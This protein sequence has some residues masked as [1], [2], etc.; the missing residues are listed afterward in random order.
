[1]PAKFDL[2]VI[3][4]G[5]AATSVAYPCRTAGWTVAIIDDRPFGGTC[6]NRGCDPKK[7]LVGVAELADS[8]RR[9]K[10]HGFTAEREHVNW[11]DLMRFKRTF[12]DPVP[13]NREREFAEAGIQ[14]YKGVARFIDADT[15]QIGDE[16]LNGEHFAIASGSGPGKLNIPGEDLLI[17][18]DQ[19]LDLEQL[20]P[21]IVFIGGG[22]IGFE[23]AHIAARAGAH[24]TIL[25]RSKRPLH[26]FDADIVDRLVDHTR[27]IGIDVRLDT[28]VDR[29]ERRGDRIVVHANG[30][31]E[32]FEASLAVHAAGRV[33]LIHNLN[34]AAA[35]I[36]SSPHGITVNEFLQSVSNPR[37][38]AA[39]DAA[40]SGA[41]QLTPIATYDGGI[42]AHNLLK[43]NHQRPIYAGCASTVFTIP[44]LASV[45]LTE[46]TARK[47]NLD[48]DVQ[49]Q[50]T[51]GWYSSRRIAEECSGFK[52]IIE[53]GTRRIL[54]AHILGEGSEEVINLFALAIRTNLTA[55]Q[56]RDNL[57]AYPTHSSNMSYMV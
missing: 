40:A 20:P 8:A 7:V 53:R 42:V 16:K 46:D 5:V 1:M 48:F 52:L 47:Q 6:A 15:L 43:G 23:F 41:P 29:L 26:H 57:F 13:G 27:K 12:T 33:P 55:D 54:G 44:P 30:G 50:D 34:P 31:S 25:H 21:D 11:P 32:R 9:M 37:V 24:V 22:Y 45:G 56:L 36:E 19:F 51:S 49:L 10:P 39:G 28:A 18:S 2:V 3:G 38:Y 35:Q 4:T 17:N 14:A